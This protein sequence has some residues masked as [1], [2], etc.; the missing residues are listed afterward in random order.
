MFIPDFFL[1]F[2]N[3]SGADRGKLPRLDLPPL[4]VLG[5]LGLSCYI[6]ADTFFIS[7]GM[8]ELPDT[9]FIRDVPA[10]CFPASWP[11]AWEP[12]ARFFP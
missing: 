9:L 6:L 4:Y 8:G 10:F 3:L 11:A 5:M 7:L 12:P 1:F 2:V